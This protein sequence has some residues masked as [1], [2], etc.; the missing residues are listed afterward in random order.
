M[1][2]TISELTFKAI[3]GI[4]P[5][6]REQSQRVVVNMSFEY[7]F[8]QGNF[9][10]YSKVAKLV[11]K[12]MKKEKFFLIEDALIALENKIQSRFSV[13]NLTIKITKPDILK[14][15]FVSVTL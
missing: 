12:T 6:E 13:S 5:F 4:L 8:S 10:D 11:K 2:V 14:D 1:K 3:L 7:E 9:I 15:C